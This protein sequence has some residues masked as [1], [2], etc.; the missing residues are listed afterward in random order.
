MSATQVAH[1]RKRWRLTVD[2]PSAQRR[3]LV[4]LVAAVAA[5]AAWLA[6]PAVR[7]L[8]LPMRDNPAQRGQRLAA[9]LG[10]FSCHGP[11]GRGG[12]PNPGSDTG[13]VPSFREGTIM[14]YAH[15]DDD[16]RAYVLDGGPAA[17]LARTRA[18]HDAPAIHMPAFR[19]VV[20]ESQADDL[21]A[22]LRSASDLL[23]PP[24]GT[25]AMHG[26]DVAVAQGCFNCHGTM[27]MGGV[28]NPGS[29]KGYIPG[30]GG[31]DFDELVRDDDELRSWITRGG[32]A[33][34]NDNPLATYFIERQRIRMPTYEQRLPAADVEALIAYV[35][36]LAT[37]EWRHAPFNG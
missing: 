32:I 10:C 35:R 2:A 1:S 8:I 36:W 21:V 34:L 24:D 16:L 4:F 22:Y 30:F 5:Q 25:P 17:R 33:R 27:G 13:Q 29:L 7:G 3:V 14:M 6:Y 19:S 11:G 26:A 31:A 15:G 9:E 37:D 20:S 18:S 28:P 12:M 23:V